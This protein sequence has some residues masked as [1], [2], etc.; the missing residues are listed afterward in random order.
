[1]EPAGSQETT[2]KPQERIWERREHLGSIE[3]IGNRGGRGS[4]GR[5]TG[6]GFVCVFGD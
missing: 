2:Y 3:N 1:M 4:L 5:E 6:G